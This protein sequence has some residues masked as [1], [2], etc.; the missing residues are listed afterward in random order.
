MIGESRFV[1]HPKMAAISLRTHAY[2]AFEFSSAKPSAIDPHYLLCA[3]FV[4]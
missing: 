1:F 2:K 3:G 4:R